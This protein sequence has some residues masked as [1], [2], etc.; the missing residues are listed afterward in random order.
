[1]RPLIVH[2]LSGTQ[3]EHR[4]LGDLIQDPEHWRERAQA[5]RVQAEQMETE[6]RRR[7]MLRIAESYDLLAARAEER[8]QTS[9]RDGVVR[10][11]KAAHLAQQYLW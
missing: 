6:S 3:K 2:P 9:T 7:I 11:T 5:A 10:P 1:M 4:A 8:T